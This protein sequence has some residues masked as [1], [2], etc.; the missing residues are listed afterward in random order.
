[1]RSKQ[2]PE[3]DNKTL[4]WYLRKLWPYFLL[5]GACFLLY[6]VTLGY[7]FSPM[8]ERWLITQEQATLSHFSNLPKLFT[9][10]TL[11]FYYRPFLNVTFMIDTVTGGGDKM[12]FHLTNI[13]L[14]AVCCALLFRF[15]LVS[16]IEKHVA[17]FAALLFAVHPVNVHAV[18]WIPG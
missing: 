4:P 2:D 7:G 6:A 3:S 13:L 12:Y 11:G 15:F 8:D 1:M 18:A 16:G 10:S 5:A 9:T 17:F 14:H